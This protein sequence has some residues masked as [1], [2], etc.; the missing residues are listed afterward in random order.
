MG[1]RAA[2]TPAE[3]ER[4]YQAKLQGQTAAE[5]AR[6]L[7]CS[8]ACVRK[9]WQRATHEGLRGLHPR[10]RGPRPHGVL[11]R[12]D[13]RVAAA[14]LALKRHH[15]RWGADRVLLALQEDPQLA[16]LHLPS[17]S[18]LAAF[19]KVQCPE[20]VQPPH[21]LTPAPARP[22]AA[23][24]VHEIWQLD[25][26]EGLRLQ[27]GEVATICNIRDPFGAA[28]SASRA[29]AVKQGARWRKVRFCEIRQV[30][31]AAF[32]EWQT[33][34]DAIQTDNEAVLAG[35]PTDP[36]P[37]LL[38]LWL[39]GL[40]VIHQFIRPNTPTDQAQVERDH[41]T[42]DNFALDAESQANVAALQQALDRERQIYNHAFPAR[43][44]DCQ[45]RPPL[46]AHPELL[47]GR[48]PYRAEWELALFDLQ[49]VFAYLATFTFERKVT[50]V[51][52]VRLGDQAYAIG[53]RYAGLGV[54]VRCDATSGEWCFCQVLDE[55]EVE[56]ARR[57]LKQLDIQTLTGL[58]PDVMAPPPPV[59]LTL[60]FLVATPAADATKL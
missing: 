39:R 53:R 35:Q 8:P 58:Q 38:T 15:E 37:S 3:L 30:L 56:L 46:L 29:V 57:P 36:F 10:P 40:G 51:G 28:M 4:L 6:A 42:L 26:Q 19:F 44:S 5:I 13:P 43:A 2:L 52:Q 34:P 20:C 31:R 41:R 50:R 54:R 11:A 45:R 12:T 1:Q 16:A 23:T 18:R 9:W 60:P 32:N 47:Q 7:A 55:A 14:A 22:P 24:A 17:R 48:R 59:Q 33:L 25:C 27:D 49:H 21:P